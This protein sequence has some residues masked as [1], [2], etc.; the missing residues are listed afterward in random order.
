MAFPDKITLQTVDF[1]LVSRSGTRAV[2]S[3]PLTELDNPST[4]LISH[5]T[6]KNGRVSSVVM[7]EENV[8]ISCNDTCDI[9]PQTS[10]V[11]VMLK[12]Q[13]N[14]LEGYPD[15]AVVI[16]RLFQQII[17]AEILTDFLP[18]MLNKES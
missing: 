12:I 15:Q 6:A 17:A 11:K 13:Y 2:R 9:V 5:E 10:N 16:E 18:K 8:V 14:P 3:D 4:L 1:D 7:R